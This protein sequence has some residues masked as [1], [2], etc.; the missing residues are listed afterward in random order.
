MN[1]FR[2][3]R[4]A[5]AAFATLVSLSLALLAGCSTTVSVLKTAATTT[6]KISANSPTACADLDGVGVAFGKIVLQVAAANPSNAVIQKAA[7]N[8]ASGQTA[9]NAD[10]IVAAGLAGLL[11]VSVS[12]AA[13]TASTR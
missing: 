3:T 6:A 4:R 5:G 8:Y 2:I 7:A 9:T 13:A 11:N 12:T 1:K 10:C